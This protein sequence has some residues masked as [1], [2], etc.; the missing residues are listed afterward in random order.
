MARVRNLQYQGGIVEQPLYDGVPLTKWIHNGIVVWENGGGDN[1]LIAFHVRYSSAYHIYFY[2]WDMQ[3]NELSLLPLPFGK[4]Y[5]NPFSDTAASMYSSDVGAFPNSIPFTNYI[6]RPLHQGGEIRDPYLIFG[7][8]SYT[9][10]P[11]ESVQ[12]S[13][14]GGLSYVTM[15]DAR[16]CFWSSPKISYS[17]N[18]TRSGDNYIC[19]VV[20]ISVDSNVSSTLITRYSCSVADLFGSSSIIMAQAS[21]FDIERPYEYLSE[22]VIM[23]IPWT[24]YFGKKYSNSKTYYFDYLSVDGTLTEFHTM[25]YVSGDTT[26]FVKSTVI[27]STFFV[28]F[29]S[30]G[31]ATNEATHKSYYMYKNR[32][33]MITQDGTVRHIDNDYTTDTRNN[34]YLHY[35]Q[36]YFMYDAEN[37]LYYI[38]STDF[39]NSSNAEKLMYICINKR[40]EIVRTHKNISKQITINGTEYT[41]P[42]PASGYNRESLYRMYDNQGNFSLF[43]KQIKGFLFSVDPGGTQRQGNTLIYLDNYELEVNGNTVVLNNPIIES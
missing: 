20:R 29:S 24:F 43:N 13:T 37:E 19:N 31:L 25:P 32:L 11:E 5:S 33:F 18:Y 36:P 21:A 38:Y 1:V 8:G 27:G 17:I 6:Y 15:T 22:S 16:R 2:N 23:N 12:I 4:T 42:I 7:D 26:N 10:F 9:D 35:Y 14:A 34:I 39:E 41:I 28:T 30:Y 3:T 40:C